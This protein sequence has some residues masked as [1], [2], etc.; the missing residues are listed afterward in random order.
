MQDS[1][2]KK[3]KQRES[4]TV[5]RQL[6]RKEN[7]KKNTELGNQSS[8]QEKLTHL[9]AVE[10]ATTEEHGKQ[11]NSRVFMSFLEYLQNIKTCMSGLELYEAE[12]K[13]MEKP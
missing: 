5:F 7:P 11:G 6:N 10:Q 1:A 8:Q 4:L 9:G 2:L 3:G 13:T 12:Q